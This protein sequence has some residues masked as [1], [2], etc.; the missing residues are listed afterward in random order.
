MQKKWFANFVNDPDNEF[1][2]I[3]KDLGSNFRKID[4]DEIIELCIHRE[5]GI[6]YEML[7]TQIYEFDIKISKKLFERI[8]KLGI[9]LEMNS[10]NWEDLKKLI[11]N[12]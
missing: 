12:Q 8:K 3:I 2:S 11:I 1:E 10:D 7:C 9:F 4:R 5:C 6:A